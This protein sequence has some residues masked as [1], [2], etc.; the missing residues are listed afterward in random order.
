VIEVNTH[1]PR[2]IRSLSRPPMNASIVSRTAMKTDEPWYAV[3]WL[4]EHRDLSSL[5]GVPRSARA[6]VRR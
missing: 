1:G 4:F 6:G 5:D 2:S 3:R